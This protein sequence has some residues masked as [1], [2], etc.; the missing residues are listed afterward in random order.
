MGDVPDIFC[1]LDASNV[2]AETITEYEKLL[3]LLKSPLGM[4]VAS[5]SENMSTQPMATRWKRQHNRINIDNES[6]GKLKIIC[7]SLTLHGQKL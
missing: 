3:S 4:D 2:R 5:S 7:N 6:L 1:N